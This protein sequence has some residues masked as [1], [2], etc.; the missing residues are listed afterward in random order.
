MVT[1]DADFARGFA[2]SA[3]VLDSIPLILDVP[4]KVDGTFRPIPHGSGSAPLST[5]QARDR[6]KVEFLTSNRGA[7]EY[8]DKPAHMPALGGTAA[9]PRDSW[10]SSSISLVLLHRA[11]INVLVP[12]PARYAVH[13][14]IIANRRQSEQ[15]GLLKQEK[16]ITQAG[17]IIEAV[18]LTRR[19]DDFK[20]AWERGPGGG[21]AYRRVS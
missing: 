12:V 3:E 15:G 8:A 5:F 21:K 14:L 6:Y 4:W 16:D 1:G 19:M 13:K 17:A 18:A 9:D 2:V 11:G 7:D 20:E 10:V